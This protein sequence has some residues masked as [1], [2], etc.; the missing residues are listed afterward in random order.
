MELFNKLTIIHMQSSL[1]YLPIEKILDRIVVCKRL[2][3]HWGGKLKQ[4]SKRALRLLA[5]R[6]SG[7]VHCVQCLSHMYGLVVST[8]SSTFSY[9]WH[10]KW[11]QSVEWWR[12]HNNSRCGLIWPG[13]ASL[14]NIQLRKSLAWLIVKPIRYFY[15]VLWQFLQ[16][17]KIYVHAKVGS[18]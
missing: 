10:S 4:D 2:H 6:I 11:R 8:W 7:S 3:C 14:M 12:K 15:K 1:A 16:V 18:S 5:H 17:G 9:W 13:A